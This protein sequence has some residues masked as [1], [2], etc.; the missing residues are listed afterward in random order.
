MDNRSSNSKTKV[1]N[2][3]TNKLLNKGK[4]ILVENVLKVGRKSLQPT[5]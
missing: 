5:N 3:V 4:G 1:K 2:K